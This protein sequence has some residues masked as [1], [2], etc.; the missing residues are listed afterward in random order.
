MEADQ[1]S[2]EDL[3]SVTEAVEGSR[4]DQI[5][6]MPVMA[7]VVHRQPQVLEHRRGVEELHLSRPIV[8]EWS[9][10]LEKLAGQPTNPV[11]ILLGLSVVAEHVLDTEGPYI[12]DEMW[13]LEEPPE[14]RTLAQPQTGDPDSIEIC[15][16]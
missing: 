7:I 15:L 1:E 8:M 16:T 9:Q 14:Q 6:T 12:G 13:L 5:G 10:T 2:Q 11:E 3:L 4:G